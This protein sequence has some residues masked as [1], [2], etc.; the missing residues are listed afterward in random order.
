[1]KHVSLSAN[2]RCV[3]RR[4]AFRCTA[5]DVEPNKDERADG[6]RSSELDVLTP[7]EISSNHDTEV[8]VIHSR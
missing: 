1:M 7:A 6:F 8:Q 3:G 2:Q 4:F 5:V